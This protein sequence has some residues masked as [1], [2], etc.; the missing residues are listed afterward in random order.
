ML[1]Q[2]EKKYQQLEKYT[3]LPNMNIRFNIIL[4][5]EEFYNFLTRINEDNF[6]EKELLKYVEIGNTISLFFVLNGM[7]CINT[8]IIPGDNKDLYLNNFL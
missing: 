4:Y 3:D 7:T 8:K 6:T 2:I 1:Y 5:F